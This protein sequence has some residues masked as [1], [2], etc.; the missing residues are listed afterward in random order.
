MHLVDKTIYYYLILFAIL[1]FTFSLIP[2][3]FEIIQQKLTSNIP[4]IS[5]ICM[6]LSFIIYLFVTISRRYYIHIFF[7]LICLICI[8]IILFLKS[9]YD[10]NNYKISKNMNILDDSEK[11]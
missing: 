7:Y 8:S 3:V 11:L 9:K 2:I 1:L 4:Y 6:F 10:N 5:L